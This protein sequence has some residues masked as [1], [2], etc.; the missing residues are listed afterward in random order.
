M[1]GREVEPLL[2]AL[3]GSQLPHAER[4]ALR[5]IVAQSYTF[6]FLPQSPDGSDAEA[7]N[8]AAGEEALEATEAE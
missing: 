1:D 5:D 4:L 3:V 2:S 8:L 7:I 6:G